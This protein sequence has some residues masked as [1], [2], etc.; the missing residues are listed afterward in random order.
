M[1]EIATC[2][3]YLAGDFDG[4]FAII[5]PREHIA[6]R[7]IQSLVDTGNSCPDTTGC[8]VVG[9][10]ALGIVTGIDVRQAVERSVIAGEKWL[11][12]PIDATAHSELGGLLLSEL[13]N[14]GE[15]NSPG[16]PI[17]WDNHRLP[18]GRIFNTGGLQRL[19]VDE[20]HDGL[21]QCMFA[22]G[23]P[24]NEG[25]DVDIV[26]DALSM[27]LEPWELVPDDS[28]LTNPH[29]LLDMIQEGKSARAFAFQYMHP[30]ERGE[31]DQMAGLVVGSVLFSP[32]PFYGRIVSVVTR[33]GAELP[34]LP[35]A[36]W[37]DQNR[38][39]GLH[40]Q[41]LPGHRGRQVEAINP[42]SQ[43]R[44]SWAGARVLVEVYR[45]ANSEDQT[46]LRE[47]LKMGENQRKNLHYFGYGDG[48][49]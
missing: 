21:E 9:R 31:Y 34:Q 7:T 16:H 43:A 3:G 38:S 35:S 11:Q 4:G 22:I 28:V 42:D 48:R 27:P 1:K 24:D 14:L 6:D 10:S 26:E 46:A 20:L 49:L 30:E 36:A 12:V 29:A 45:P 33:D 37:L 17:L 32:G 15:K 23:S 18:F 39:P 13:H 25:S 44:Y 8:Q 47:W 41:F 19:T 5:F 40:P 2:D